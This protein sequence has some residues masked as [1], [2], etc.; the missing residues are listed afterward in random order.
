MRLLKP[1]RLRK[2]DVIGLVAPASPP[3]SAAR[4]HAAVR[5]LEDHGYHVKLGRH[6]NAR[7][8]FFAGTDTQRAADLNALFND[9]QVRAIFALRGGYGTPRLLPLVDYAAARRHPKILV[10]YSDLTALQLALFRQTGLVTFSGPMLAA[11]LRG[12]RLD[13]FTES[14]FWRM[15]TSPERVGVLAGP[16]GCTG[17]VRHPGRAEGRL[18]GGNLSLLVS[19]LGTPFSPDYRGALLFLEDVKEHLHRLDRMFT[20]LRNAGVLAQVAGLLL[21]HF[22]GCRPSNRRDPQ[23]TREQILDQVL[24]WTP[25]PAVDRFCYGHVRRRL[26]LPLGLRARLDAD[27]GELEVLESAVS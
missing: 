24:A 26:T 22:T 6:L 8:G 21:G 4:V 15:L 25:A 7:H 2:G 10:G 20:Q 1:P 12:G 9:S 23:L 3:R 5:Y 11:D 27:R 14:R 16:R 18:L 17:R 19:S 13:P